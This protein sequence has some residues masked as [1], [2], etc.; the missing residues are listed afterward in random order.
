MDNEGFRHWLTAK[1]KMPNK[2]AGDTISRCR[3]VERLLHLSM[4]SA[5]SSQESADRAYIRLIRL[6]TGL[7]SLRYAMRL[8]TANGLSLPLQLKINA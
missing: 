4:D 1:K 2:V 5:L 7:G 3:K 8:Y 6:G